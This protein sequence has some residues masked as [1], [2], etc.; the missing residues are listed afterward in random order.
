MELKNE[1]PI[2]RLGQRI[3]TSAQYDLSGSLYLNAEGVLEEIDLKSVP[4]FVIPFATFIHLSHSR[5]VYGKVSTDKV[6]KGV[7]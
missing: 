6:A 3:R 1:R 4:H 5:L 7:I 2:S